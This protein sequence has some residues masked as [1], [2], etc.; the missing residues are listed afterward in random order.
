M[1]RATVD[2]CTP[3]RRLPADFNQACGTVCL[4]DIPKRRSGLDWLKLIRITDED[5]FAATHPKLFRNAGKLSR[6]NHSSLINHDNIT[7]A[8]RFIS[9][10]PACFQG[11][12]GA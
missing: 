1:D 2:G 5:E 4:H 8:D 12:Q 6:A 10:F 9:A 7:F 11:R 3:F